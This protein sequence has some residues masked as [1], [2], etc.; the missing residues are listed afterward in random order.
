MKIRVGS[1]T[2][3]GR[4]RTANEDSF[5]R[6][7]KGRV[8]AVADGMG[9]HRAGDV[10]S[11]TALETFEH[12]LDDGATLVDAI[13][14]ANAEV[15][16]KAQANPEMRGMGTTVTAVQLDDEKALVGHVGDSRAYLLRDGELTQVTEDHSLVEELVREGR[17]TPEEAAVHPQR[18]II[19][20]A[21]GVDEAVE[22]DTYEIDLR[23]DDRIVVCSDGLTSMMRDEEIAG[24]LRAHTNPEE[25][26]EKLVLAANRAGGEDNITVLVIDVE[27]DKRRGRRKA[28]VASEAVVP[29]GDEATGEWERAEPP[30][31][32]EAPEEPESRPPRRRRLR[33]ALLW[34]IPIL[35][36][37]GVAAGALGWY[38]R[39][40]YFVGVDDNRVVL[41]RG[42]PDGFLVWDPTVEEQTDLRTTDLNNAQRDD[43]EDGHR[44]S[45]RN[46]ADAFLARLERST[47]TTTTSTTTT[48][49][50]ALPPA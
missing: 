38:A 7:D 40:G 49:A 13:V 41:Y 18:S 42:V 3:V 1:A 23:P 8:F 34:V 19:T 32:E 45:S 37:L 4:T 35:L 17:L 6:D 30:E 44:F 48:T 46:G 29:V 10:A 12:E 43:L 47:T 14:A 27:G 26:A 2:D 5:L 15:F 31:V 33:R 11:A 24:V 36:V 9:G 39:N 16:A 28:L 50:P 25:A 22:V 21:L 20:R